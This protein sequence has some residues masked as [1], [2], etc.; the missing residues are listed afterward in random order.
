MKHWYY[1]ASDEPNK[2][3]Y[4]DSYDDTQ[5]AILCRFRFKAPINEIPDYSVYKDDELIE[6][7]TGKMLMEI[8]LENGGKVFQDCID[9]KS[10]TETKNE[11]KSDDLSS[12]IESACNTMKNLAD[13]I[14]RLND[15]LSRRR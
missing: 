9:K 3:N 4:F 13:N 2:R 10:K 11:N 6:I 7:A 8:Y 15:I 14:D 12:V 1:I 5:F